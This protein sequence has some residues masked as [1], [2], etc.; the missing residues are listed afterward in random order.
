MNV[1]TLKNF[2]ANALTEKR[3]ITDLI[4]ES[5]GDLYQYMRYLENTDKQVESKVIEDYRT[6]IFDVRKKYAN[7][8]VNADGVKVVMDK[9]Y[10]LLNIQI[11][12]LRQIP[13]REWECSFFTTYMN[14]L[15]DFKYQLKP[16]KG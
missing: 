4:T 1:D 7:D 16:N 8:D 5:A 11:I 12:M 10:D 14:E 13:G 9:I 3:I 6:Q 15:A 2:R